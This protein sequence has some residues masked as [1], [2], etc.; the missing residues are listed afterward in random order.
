MSDY[1]DESLDSNIERS[2]ATS[3]AKVKEKGVAS[4]KKGTPTGVLV[5]K[6]VP[7]STGKRKTSK[8]DNIKG[9]GSSPK[10]SKT[11][12]TPRDSAKG[13]GPSEKASTYK[14]KEKVSSRE[15]QQEILKVYL[16][17]LLLVCEGCLSCLIG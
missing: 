7:K 11:S 3:R 15:E 2:V 13:V 8:R 12:R 1:D 5:K 10:S 4:P 16:T 17:Q 9:T 6:S 14:R